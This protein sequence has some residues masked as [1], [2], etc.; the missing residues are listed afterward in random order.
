M[1]TMAATLHAVLT[2][3]NS[4]GEGI[5]ENSDKDS[6]SNDDIDNPHMAE[7]QSLGQRQPLQHHKD[8]YHK[9]CS[10]LLLPTCTVP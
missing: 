10:S 6:N 5:K 8:M 3:E 7:I 1:Q 9:Q 2:G 4:N